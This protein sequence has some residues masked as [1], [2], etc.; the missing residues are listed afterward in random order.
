ML[1]QLTQGIGARQKE[2][3]PNVDKLAESKN[4]L[5][6]NSNHSEGIVPAESSKH[7]WNLTWPSIHSLHY[8][9]DLRNTSILLHAL[10][11]LK[12]RLETIREQIISIYSVSGCSGTIQIRSY[13][14]IRRVL[15]LWSWQGGMLVS[16]SG[17]WKEQNEYLIL[18]PMPPSPS[19]QFP[20]MNKKKISVQ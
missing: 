15:P 11:E 3:Y 12:S 9:K 13:N 18:R 16:R 6:E 20:L 10:K 2:R 5:A 8:L 17:G 19:C 4:V 7:C 1:W 14:F